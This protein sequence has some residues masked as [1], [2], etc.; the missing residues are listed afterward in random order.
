MNAGGRKKALVAPLDWG[1]G[2]ATR[3]MPLIR[4]LTAEDYE[5]ILASTGASGELLRH[6]FPELE[7]IELKSFRVR[8]SRGRSQIGAM[9]RLLPS[10]VYHSVL[11][12]RELDRIV[13]SRAIDLVI[14]DNRFGLWSRRTRSLYM[15]HQLM[16]KMPRGLKFLEGFAHRLHL[17]VIRHYDEC[18]VPDDDDLRLSGDLAFRYPLP[19]NARLIGPLSRYESEGKVRPCGC[20]ALISGAEPQRSIFE[21]EILSRLEA[22]DGDA[23]VV[24]GLPGKASEPPRKKGRIT[25]YPYLGGE[26]LAELI[27]GAEKIICRSGYSSIMDLCALG[28]LDAAE[29]HP[30]PGQ[31]EQEYLAELHAGRSEQGLG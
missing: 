7:H 11:E 22:F 20:L 18:L 25:I 10:I 28:R 27:R 13:R 8:Y 26:E 2:H 3:C 23:V 9:A 17:W 19:P 21:R 1:L 6:E 4:K 15:T 24:E 12:H 5:V 30:T 31:T 14:S 16:I 29:L